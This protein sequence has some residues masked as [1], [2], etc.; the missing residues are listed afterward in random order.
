[1]SRALRLGD[2]Y[3]H[4][5]TSGLGDSDTPEG[6]PTDVALSPTAYYADAAQIAREA[7]RVLDRPDEAA[8]FAALFD[9]IRADFNDRF[10]PYRFLRKLVCSTTS[11]GSVQER[12]S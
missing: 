8:H 12:E 3:D 5:L 4:T 10:L 9:S 2:D 6:T 11:N 1:M 7:A